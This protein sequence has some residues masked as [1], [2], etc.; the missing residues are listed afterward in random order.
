VPHTGGTRFDDKPE[1]HQRS[2][3]GWRPRPVDLPT[4][5]TPGCRTVSEKRGNLRRAPTQQ[6]VKA[7]HSDGTERDAPC[8]SS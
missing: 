8:G 4:V 3:A 5:A 6:M 2:S 7:K 1:L